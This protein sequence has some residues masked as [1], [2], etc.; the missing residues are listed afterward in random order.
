[1]SL[2]QTGTTQA[3]EA[4]NLYPRA[5][6]YIVERKVDIGSHVKTGDVLF[7]I[8]APDLDQQLVQAQSQVLQLQAALTQS[9]AMVDQAE[10]NRH[11]ADVTNRRT[12]TLA[13]TGIATAQNANT[14]Q[15]GVLTQTANAAATRAAV[16][17]AEANITAQEAQVAR[18]KV[19][20]GFEEVRAPFDGMVT[21]R[22][23]DV[24]DAVLADTTTGAPLLTL[25]RDDVLRMAVN[26]PLYVADGVREGLDARV[27]VAQIPGKV[28]P[29]KVSRSSTTLLSAART[30]VTQ[31]DIPNPDGALRA[32]LYITITLEIPRVSPAVTVPSDALIF[33]QSGTRVAVV[34][35]EAEGPCVVRM[36]S[37]TIFRQ[38]QTALELRGGLNGGERVVIGPPASLRDGD[39]ITVR[40]DSGTAS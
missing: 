8:S 37:V 21:T 9:Q 18:L 5:T 34:E 40:P 31:V 15:A 13:G 7:R 14:A 25:A 29:G 36:R 12:S 28:F 30:L 19:L 6:G 3:F 4:A 39:R 2:T 23:N 35:T 27:E 38:T 20:T 22:N 33:D 1:M 32:G 24:G 17:V 16:K 10:A 26:V 11:L